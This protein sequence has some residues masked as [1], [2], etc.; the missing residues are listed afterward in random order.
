MAT[1]DITTGR[2]RAQIFSGD[3]TGLFP[4]PTRTR[5]HSPTVE[6][7]FWRPTGSRK[8]NRCPRWRHGTVPNMKAENFDAFVLP[9]GAMKPDTLRINTD[10]A[11]SGVT[12]SRPPSIRTDVMNA[13]ANWVAESVV[14]DRGLVT[15]RRPKDL[16]EFN[17][18]MVEEFSEAAPAHP[19]AYGSSAS[20][21]SPIESP[22]RRCRD[23]LSTLKPRARLLPTGSRSPARRRNAR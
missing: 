13:G 14:S 6:S 4:I 12:S 23:G 11:R 22:P 16:A 3:V 19:R 21:T 8:Q 5:T 9:G 18:K 20:T 1:N 17:T 7:Q 2:I 10:A 15:S